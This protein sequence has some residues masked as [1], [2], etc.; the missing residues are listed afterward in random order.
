MNVHIRWMIRRDMSDVLEIERSIYGSAAWNEDNFIT[1]LRQRNCIGMV[2]ETD[3]KIIG[4]MLY[5]LHKHRLNIIS[6]AVA[7]DWRRLGVGTQMVAKLAGKLSSHRR[8]SLTLAVRESNLDAQLFFRSQG[9][10]A[11]GVERNFYEDT[12]EDAYAMEYRLAD[13]SSGERNKCR[14]QMKGAK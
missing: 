14:S 1:C 9:F 6:F 3:E 12:G 11:T 5:E 2:V 8:T 13:E 10:A 4:F 7:F